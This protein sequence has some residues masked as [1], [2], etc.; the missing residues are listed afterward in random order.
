[1]V[2]IVVDVSEAEEEKTVVPNVSV[3][4]VVVVVKLEVCLANDVLLLLI[5]P[6][7]ILI[8]TKARQVLKFDAAISEE[9][10]RSSFLFC[11]SIWKE[12]CWLML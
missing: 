11:I 3:V 12:Y 10:E 1:M 9:Q 2:V 4:L 6:L 7:R 8:G 5:V